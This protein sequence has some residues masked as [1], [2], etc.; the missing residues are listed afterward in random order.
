[1]N[2]AVDAFPDGELQGVV[3]S[4]GEYPLPSL[5]PYSTVKEYAAEIEITNPPEAL[6]SGMTAKVGIQ[7][8]ALESAVQVPVQAVLEREDRHFCFVPDGDG[9]L[10]ARE[11]E[12]G[13][14]NDSTVVI[15]KGLSPDEQVFLAP[16]NYENQVTLPAPEPSL[17]QVAAVGS[18]D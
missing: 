11:V 15:K 16:Q 13:P 5:I 7:V 1:V 3:Q 14:M 12:L 10:E 8:A 9:H 2:I 18:G 4:V 17:G 6:R